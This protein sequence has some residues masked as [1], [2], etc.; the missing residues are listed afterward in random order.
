MS[1]EPEIHEEIVAMPSTADVKDDR[2]QVRLDT[3]AKSALQRAAS[4]RH[5]LLSKLPAPFRLVAA[6]M[7]ACGGEHAACPIGDIG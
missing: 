2:L 5:K 6:R 1:N 4:D 7:K 3:E